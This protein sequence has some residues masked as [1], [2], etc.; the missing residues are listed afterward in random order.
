MIVIRKTVPHC[1]NALGA[2]VPGGETARYPAVDGD[3]LV[4]EDTD[5]K[6]TRAVARLGPGPPPSSRGISPRLSQIRT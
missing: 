6:D 5:G 2:P 3:Y 1:V 4:Y